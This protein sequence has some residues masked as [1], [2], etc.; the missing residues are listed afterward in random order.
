MTGLLP[1]RAARAT[2]PVRVGLCG[3]LGT[4]NLGND[5][6]LEAVLALLR[7]EYPDAEF[8]ALCSG[9]DEIRSRFGVAA[10]PLNWYRG[11]YRTATRAA[12]VGKLVGKIVDPVRIWAWVRRHDVVVVPG[13][14]VLEGSLPLRPWG[15][16]YS[17]L[18]LCLAGRA[19]GTRVALVCVG[20]DELA[21]PLSRRIIVR[22]ARLAHYRS[23]R[24]APSRDAMRAMG[25][26]AAA[27]DGVFPDLAFALPLPPEQPV[28]PRTV[29][30]GV[31]ALPA[32]RSGGSPTGYLDGITEFV[33][34]LLDDGYDVSL[35]TGDREDEAVASRIRADLRAR[36]GDLGPDRLTATT[37][38]SLT[39][40]MTLMRPLETIVATRYH[41]VV[42]ALRL[43]KPTVSVGYAAK[44]DVLMAQMG[45]GD[46]CQRTDSLDVSR[47]VEQ[48]RAVRARGDAPGP[49]T[50]DRERE[51]AEGLRRQVT[52]LVAAVFPAANRTPGIPGRGYTGR[53]S[54]GAA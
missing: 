53:S 10:T 28:R 8:G 18:M 20:A 25:L 52:A 11:E 14:G 54:R 27:G 31:M 33:G 39:E 41:N 19:T 38:G 4:G 42:C 47:L 26:D 5:G 48:F 17:L 22:A 32:D 7:A 2:D 24:D 13:M 12:I 49:S 30:V 40:L 1:R 16:P 44:N 43:G 3:L 51:P 34:R 36:R 29:G 15:W 23:F 50:A 35:L 45:M 9:P 46:A 37:P 6:S 21:R